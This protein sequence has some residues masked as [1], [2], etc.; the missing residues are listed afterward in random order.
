MKFMTDFFTEK[1]FASSDYK[2]VL[3]FH[4]IVIKILEKFITGNYLN[5]A[6]LDF[7][8][9]SSFSEMS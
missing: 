8:K 6:M 2:K 7:Y 9:D 4:K 5:F 1:K 3:R